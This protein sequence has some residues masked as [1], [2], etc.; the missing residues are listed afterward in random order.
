MNNNF[1]K[2]HKIRKATIREKSRF[3]KYKITL[4]EDLLFKKHY[5]VYKNGFFFVK[6]IIINLLFFLLLFF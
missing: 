2:K 3:S 1:N 4:I 6:L 5:K